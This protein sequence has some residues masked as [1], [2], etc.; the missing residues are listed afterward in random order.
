M[1]KLNKAIESMNSSVNTMQA[2][3][4]NLMAKIPINSALNP[5]PPIVIAS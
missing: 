3:I 1:N 5:P 4:N 2:L